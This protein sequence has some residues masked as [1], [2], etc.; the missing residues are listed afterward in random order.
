M[1]RSILVL[2][3]VA[4]TAS[5]QQPALVAAPSTRATTVVTLN[6]PRGAQGMS[7][8]RIRID[9]GQ[10]HLRGRT[11][12]AGGIVPMDSV[13]RL[14]ANEATGFD[15]ELDLVI[16]GHAVPKGKY[17]LYTLPT[18]AGWKLIINKNTGQWGT[19]YRA[20]H[21]LVRVD[22]RHRVLNQPVESFSMWL[23]P[24]AQG[25]PANGELRFAW[26]THELSTSWTVR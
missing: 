25:T 17:T 16:G 26:G 13:W 15:A 5:A 12:H 7:S 21:D 19:D 9:Y 4:S 10:P 8:A 18:A 24:S 6:P 20:E 2:A 22:L 1:N 23:I 11:L 14:G 3:V